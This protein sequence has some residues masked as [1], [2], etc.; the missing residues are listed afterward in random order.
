MFSF[1]QSYPAGRYLAAPLRL[2][3]DFQ[4]V[5]PDLYGELDPITFYEEL[6][7][8]DHTVRPH[9]MVNAIPSDPMIAA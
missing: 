7:L 8:L 6:V 4:S 5:R 3:R 1:Y 2:I 9:V